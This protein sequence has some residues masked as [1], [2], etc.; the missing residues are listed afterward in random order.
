M[1]PVEAVAEHPWSHD[2]VCVCVCVCHYS[3]MSS[4]ALVDLS[5]ILNRDPHI[6]ETGHTGTIIIITGVFVCVCGGGVSWSD[7]TVCV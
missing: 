5:D 7:L 3:A 2:Q 4:E 6:L 1:V